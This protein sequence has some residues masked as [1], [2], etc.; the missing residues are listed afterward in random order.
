MYFKLHNC[1]HAGHEITHCS[2]L[3]LSSVCSLLFMILHVHRVSRDVMWLFSGEVHACTYE[4]VYVEVC[5]AVLVFLH[6]QCNCVCSR[7]HI[8]FGCG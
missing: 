2:W 4:C 1:Y 8:T 6:I 3:E 7:P 5:I